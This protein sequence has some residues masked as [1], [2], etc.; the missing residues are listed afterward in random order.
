MADTLEEIY[1]ATL[2]NSDFD[3]NGVKTI[4]TTNASTSY[5]LKDVQVESSEADVPIKANL[6]VNDMNVANID[7]SVTGSE[8]VGPSSTVK[9]DSSTYPLAYTDTYYQFINSSGNL[10]RNSSASLA[11]VTENG[12]TNIKSTVTPVITLTS[13]DYVG[14]WQNIGPNNVAVNILFNNNDNTRHFIY[15]SSGT[16]I[17]SVTNDYYAPRAFDGSRYLYWF[18]DGSNMKKYDTWTD[19]TVDIPSAIGSGNASTYARFAYAGNG[20][21]FGWKDYGANDTARRPFVFDS[22]KNTITTTTNGNSSNGQFGNMSSEAMWCTSDSSGN[23]Y[24][25]KVENTG[26]WYIYKI[27]SSGTISNVGSLNM[28]GS[29]SAKNTKQWSSGD[30]DGKIYFMTNNAK[31]AYY[32]SSAHSF[33]ETA[34]NFNSSSFY[35]SKGHLTIGSLTP[36]ASTIAAR[37]YTL[38]PQVTYRVTGIKSV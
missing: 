38:D 36:S 19:T 7:S 13:D 10:E 22:N 21:Y 11:G 5:V 4:I 28:G 14:Y 6:L 27:S 12:L 37:T 32:D 15:N 1:K 16:L 9:I 34:I 35:N 26:T 25:A 23:I 30:S 3:S 17:T 20:L 33:T 2:S 18:P 8:I 24:M 31:V 29:F